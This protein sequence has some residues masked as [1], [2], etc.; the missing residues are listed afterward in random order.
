M[1]AETELDAIVAEYD[2]IVRRFRPATIER[3]RL[4]IAR[5]VD[6]RVQRGATR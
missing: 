5:A 3:H 1:I 4:R 6:A 2:R